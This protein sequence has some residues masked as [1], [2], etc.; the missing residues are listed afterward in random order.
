MAVACI[1]A[2]EHGNKLDEFLSV[3]VMPNPTN[4]SSTVPI[5]GRLTSVAKLVADRVFQYPLI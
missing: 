4:R 5:P 1:N 3:G 2:M